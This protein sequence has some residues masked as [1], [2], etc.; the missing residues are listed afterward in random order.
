MLSF[1]FLLHVWLSDL[2]QALWIVYVTVTIPCYFNRCLQFLKMCKSTL[3]LLCTDWE[4]NGATQLGWAD[5]NFA[6]TMSLLSLCCCQSLHAI[7]VLDIG[8]FDRS[9][10][11]F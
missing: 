6:Y 10:G 4:R 9:D 1:L 3:S 2:K 8:L 5:I 7:V 11:I